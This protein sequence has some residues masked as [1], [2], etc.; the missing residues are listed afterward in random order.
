MVGVS[1]SVCWH[2]LVSSPD[3]TPSAAEKR[4]KEGKGRVWELTILTGVD[5]EC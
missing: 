2:T 1:A 5:L 4:G 3:P